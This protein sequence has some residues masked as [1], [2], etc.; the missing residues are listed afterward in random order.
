MS[1]ET[2]P[3]PREAETPKYPLPAGK[4]SYEEFLEWLPDDFLAEWVDGEVIPLP[5]PNI[6][7]QTISAFLL[8]SIGT[9]AEIKDLGLVL[10]APVQMKVGMGLGGREPDVLF[11]R[12][13]RLDCVRKVFIDGPADLVVEIIS[14]GHAARDRRDKF[15][16]Y[17]LGGVEEYWIIDPTRRTADFYQLDADGSYVAAKPNEGRYASRVLPG[18][19]IEEA[20]LWSPPPLLEVLRAWA[21]LG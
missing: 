8:K 13:D 10:A 19:W 6:E 18:L 2:A 15:H 3:I 12:K 14:P 4:L 9:F 5:M 1:L 16:E 21:L 20:W 17:A 11:V 7:H